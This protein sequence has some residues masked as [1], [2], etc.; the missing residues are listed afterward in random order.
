M[1]VAEIQCAL[2]WVYQK[3]PQI[4]RPEFDI[5]LVAFDVAP[6]EVENYRKHLNSQFQKHEVH[7]NQVLN[8]GQ[9]GLAGWWDHLDGQKFDRTDLY[10]GHSEEGD[11]MVAY[12]KDTHLFVFCNWNVYWSK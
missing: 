10:G 11:V 2:G 1:A 4:S 9:K 5:E 12:Q 3:F 6:S 8:C 7:T